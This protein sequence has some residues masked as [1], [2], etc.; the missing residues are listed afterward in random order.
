MRL[1][2]VHEKVPE[3]ERRR[4]GR[5]SVDDSPTVSPLDAF[6]L[7]ERIFLRKMDRRR[8]LRRTQDLPAPARS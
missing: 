7:E 4:R 2:H 3:K 5:R 8:V 1:I 6:T